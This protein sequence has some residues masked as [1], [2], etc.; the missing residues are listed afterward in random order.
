MTV[1][2]ERFPTEVEAA[3]YFVIAEGLTNVARYAGATEARVEIVADAGRLRIVVA[4]NGRGGADP[5]AGS[6][7]R[8]LADR[9]AAI[10]GRLDVASEVGAG[11]TLTA[12]LPAGA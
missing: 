9:V 2:P 7:L 6:G 12:D 1:T 10:G 11:T 3:A 8:G 4:D 5:S